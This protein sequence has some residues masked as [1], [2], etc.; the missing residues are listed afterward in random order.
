MARYIGG[1]VAVAA[2]ATVFNAVTNS[3]LHAGASQSDALAAGLA[4]AALLLAI[5]SAAGVALSVLVAR[6]RAERPRAIHRA[7]AA[8]ATAHTI[9]T[10]PVPGDRATSGSAR[11]VLRP[12]PDPT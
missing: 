11:A 8:A 9:P 10:Q 2:V 5:F 7:A 1:A 4:G 3:H 12:T 6:H